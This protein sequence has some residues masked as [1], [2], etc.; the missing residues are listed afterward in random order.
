[1]LRVMQMRLILLLLLVVTA[2]PAFAQA[3]IRK[4]EPPPPIAKEAPEAPLTVVDSEQPIPIPVPP[5][6]ASP[7]GGAQDP[8]TYARPRAPAPQQ[9]P[10]SI[11]RA[12]Y[13]QHLDRMNQITEG[14]FVWQ[15][16]ASEVTL[17]LVVFIVVAGVGLSFFQ[18]WIAFHKDG[19]I[20]DTSIEASAQNFRVTSSVV[21]IIILLISTGF[22]YLFLQHVYEIK[23]VDLRAPG[24]QAAPVAL[25]RPKT[26]AD[27]GLPPPDASAPPPSAANGLAPER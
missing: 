4:A 12:A 27:Y 25:A 10:E 5:A 7:V 8:A 17:W 22:L 16:R 11:Y 13:Y 3:T 18:I 24:D 9:S 15:D 26:A 19:K 23:V 20:G 21:G 1:M 6:A 14:K 2:A